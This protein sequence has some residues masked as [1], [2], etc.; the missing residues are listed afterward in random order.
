[1]RTP[2]WLID[3]PPEAARTRHVL[4]SGPSDQRDRFSCTLAEQ[5]VHRE[6]R[7][8][9]NL[10][11]VA[12]TRAR[13]FL[14]ISGFEQRNQGERES[15]HDLAQNALER[16]DC[17]AAPAWQG[18]TEQTRIFGIGEPGRG[19]MRRP[20]A[21]AANDDPRL[22]EPLW[23][24]QARTT[25]GR[26]SGEAITVDEDA[27]QRGIGIHYLLQQLATEPA[28]TDESLRARLQAHLQAVIDDES[29]AS[30]LAEARS[31]RAAPAL[32]HL[33]NPPQAR[34]AWNEVPVSSGNRLGVIDRLIDDG[35]V[36][37][38][39]D[40][41]TTSGDAAVLAARYRPQ[42]EAYADQVARLWPGRPL[43]AGLVLT[44]TRSW[45]EVLQR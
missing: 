18:C 40:Y 22:R 12:V 31:V 30:W 1:M 34:R 14:H 42:L 10:L 5:Q 27:A 3:W 26:P 21:A 25:A 23:I 4:I 11:Y 43:R 20:P 36:F 7:E 39:I 19:R 29:F 28:I 2:R 16:L 41:K 44:A 38:I 8:E 32:A 24:P 37:W 15:W 6:E 17:T 35:K 33:F 13:Q 45:V 9:L